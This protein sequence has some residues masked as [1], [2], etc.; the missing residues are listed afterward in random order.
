MKMSNITSTQAILRQSSSFTD[1][2]LVGEYLSIRERERKTEMS[3][4][5][6]YNKT[7]HQKAAVSLTL[8]L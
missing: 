2:G 4:E 7:L 1:A 5:L 6:K 8:G 3:L